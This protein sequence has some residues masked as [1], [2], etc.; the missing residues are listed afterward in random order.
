MPRPPTPKKAK[1]PKPDFVFPPGGAALAAVPG[2][3]LKPRTGDVPRWWPVDTPGKAA[4]ACN[5]PGVQWYVRKNMWAATH[6][7]AAGKRKSL[8]YRRPFDEI[9]A[10]RASVP[11]GQ[12]C[13]GVLVV[14]D[15]KLCVTKCAHSGCLLTNASVAAFAPEPCMYKKEFSEFCEALQHL[16]VA[17][18]EK[19]V[20]IVNRLRRSQ[21]ISCRDSNHT[22]KVDGE[23]SER[24]KCY[25]LVPEIK[26]VWIA[27][28]G[29][30]L[31]RCV[32]PRLLQG[33][34]KDRTGKDDIG[35]MLDPQYWAFRGGV[36]AM[37]RHYLSTTSTVR[38]LCMFCHFMQK[39]HAIFRGASVD[40]LSPGSNVYRN[41]K[42]KT[43]KQDY[44]NK[45]KMSKKTCQHPL[46]HDPATG[47]PRVI[48][49]ANVHAFQCAHVD[50]V[51]KEHAIGQLVHN[52]QSLKTAK[53]TID[54][55]LAKCNVYCAN[56]HHLYDTLPRRK[57]GRELLDALL[58]RGAPVACEVC[59]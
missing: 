53:P 6:T 27:K 40:T 4:F 44:V 48:T 10:V 16:S 43:E 55:E 42:Y 33:D 17:H 8:G 22:T 54:R 11:D 23:Y 18:D 58:A 5:V 9:C 57:E 34:H 59:E 36:E 52:T 49:P 35:Q 30:E 14:V 39:S 41:R 7:N 51:D 24:A 2:L 12:C 1:P 31:C 45:H 20:G 38:P 15:S 28:G 25:A 56:C 29:C 19:Y 21:C 26:Q 3:R 37:R 50:E 47:L 13:K 32:D 46:C